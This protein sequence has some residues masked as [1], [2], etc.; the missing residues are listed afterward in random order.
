MSIAHHDEHE[1]RGESDK[2]DDGDPRADIESAEPG[3]IAS[4]L[5]FF[6]AEHLRQRQAAKILT[7]IADG[8]INRRTVSTVVSF[9]ENDLARHISDEEL[10]FF[11]VLR[12]LCRPDDNIDTILNLLAEDHRAD[13]D[14][15]EKVIDILRAIM[16]G[17]EPGEAGRM[18]LRDFANHL[19]HHL[20][21]EN[22]VLLP[23]ARVRMTDD[24]LRLVA[25][26]MSIRRGVGM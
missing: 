21:L 1:R 15:S 9:I 13:E 6:F 23:I 7:L 5:D 16:N 14:A 20:A 10:S 22:G 17:D 2:A 18:T 8:F 19:R 12:P 4:P 24:A 11:P 3:L 26:S 25:Q